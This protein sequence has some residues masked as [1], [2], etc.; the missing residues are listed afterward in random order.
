MQILPIKTKGYVL[1]IDY[2]LLICFIK[3]FFIYK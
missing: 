3:I 2:N 1:F